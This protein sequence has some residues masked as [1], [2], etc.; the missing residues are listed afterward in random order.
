MAAEVYQKVGSKLRRK[1]RRTHVAAAIRASTSFSHRQR[2][3]HQRARTR[4]TANSGPTD[5]RTLAPRRDRR[6]HPAPRWSSCPPC[7]KA[8]LKPSSKQKQDALRMSF[9]LQKKPRKPS[10]SASKRKASLIFRKIVAQGISPQ[11]LEWMG[12]EA[13]EKLATS[14]QFK[15]RGHWHPKTG[16]P[17]FSARSNQS[18]T[19]FA[20]NGVCAATAGEPAGFC[21]RGSAPILSAWPLTCQLILFFCARSL[22]N[23]VQLLR[24]FRPGP[25]KNPAANKS[26]HSPAPAPACCTSTSFAMSVIFLLQCRDLRLLLGDF[27]F[28][29]SLSPFGAVF[30]ASAVASAAGV[31]VALGR[32]AFFLLRQLHFAPSQ[33]LPA[34]AYRS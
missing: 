34:A 31:P 22:C 5:Q 33:A 6:K 19:E 29:W 11:L 25:S 9:I 4:A 23:R 7:S 1:N 18:R 13:T 8:L 15:S 16:L 26:F 20:F 12:I 2:S 27:L 10:A 21:I 28:R 30:A 17:T 3:L 24:L 14:A 32:P